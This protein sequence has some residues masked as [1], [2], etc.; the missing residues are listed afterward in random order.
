MKLPSVTGP[1]HYAG[2]Y[3]FDFGDWTSIGYTAEEIALLYEREQY[4]HG[5]VF[6]I[7]RAGPDGALELQGVA[8]ERFLLESGLFFH[9]LAQ[10]AALADCA[11]LHHLAEITP[12]P[13]RA[14]LQCADYGAPAERDRYVVALIY[15]AEYEAAVSQWLLAGRYTGGDLVEGGPSHVTNYYETEKTLLERH[16]LWSAG[17]YETRTAD[18]VYASVR[19]TVQR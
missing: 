15:P 11:A 6:K 4:Q 10:T 9:R 5:K 18:E 14:K 16:Q 2:L 3:A 1:E 7:V 12:P 13:C 17:T 8:R 19:R